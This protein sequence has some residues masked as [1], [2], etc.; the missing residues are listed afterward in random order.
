MRVRG[1]D[2]TLDLLAWEPPSTTVSFPEDQVRAASLRATVARAVS[3]SLKDCAKSREDVAA[4]ISEYLGEPVGKNILDAYASEAREDHVINVVRFMALIHATGD[5]RLLQ[6]L[7]EPFGLAVVEQRYL[8]AIEEAM[9]ADAIE[10][11][12]AKIEA[13]SKRQQLARR[14]WKG[15]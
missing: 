14:R 10:E 5:V 6:M 11:L 7:A 3:L 2:K 9:T 12:S 4:E 13:L 8:P 15:A 1:D